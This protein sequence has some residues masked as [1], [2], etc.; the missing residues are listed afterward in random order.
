MKKLII[1][2][3]FIALFSCKNTG[4]TAH[5]G[6]DTSIVNAGYV[7]VYNGGAQID[8]AIRIITDTIKLIDKKAVQTTDTLYYIKATFPV[9]NPSDPT[10]KTS[11]KSLNGTDSISVRYMPIPPTKVF[12]IWGQPIPYREYI[13]AHK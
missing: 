1:F 5:S 11:L 2:V 12:Q 13:N 9:L 10:H 4:S 6:N 8:T 3:A 7:N